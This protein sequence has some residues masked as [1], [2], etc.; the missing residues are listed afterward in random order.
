MAT[1]QSMHAE[2]RRTDLIKETSYNMLIT[3]PDTTVEAKR[4]MGMQFAYSELT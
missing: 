4:A 2:K 1:T 3:Y